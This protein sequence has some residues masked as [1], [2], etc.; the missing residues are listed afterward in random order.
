FLFWEFK[1]FLGKEKKL[2]TSEDTLSPFAVIIQDCDG[3]Q[4]L[5]QINSHRRDKESNNKYYTPTQEER[6]V[7]EIMALAFHME[8]RSL[9]RKQSVQQQQCLGCKKEMD[10]QKKFVRADTTIFSC[11]HLNLCRGCAVKG[12][13]KMYN[14][15]SALPTCKSYKCSGGIPEDIPWMMFVDSIVGYYYELKARVEQQFEN[16]ACG[17]DNMPSTDTLCSLRTPLKRS[18]MVW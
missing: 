13:T 4:R 10:P 9:E 14:Q 16:K 17:T 8:T 2:L 3:L 6:R 18:S 5:N 15:E 12:I 11:K 7:E 1:A